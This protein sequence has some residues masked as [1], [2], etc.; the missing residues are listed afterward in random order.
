[1]YPLP[2]L[3]ITYYAFV[4][5]LALPGCINLSIARVFFGEEFLPQASYSTFPPTITWE[6]DDVKLLPI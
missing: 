5:S 4:L 3:A 2:Q 1:M 6:V